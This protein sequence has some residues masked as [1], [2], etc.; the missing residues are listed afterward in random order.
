MTLDLTRAVFW[1]VHRNYPWEPSG[2]STGYTTDS[3]HLP[4]LS[5][6]HGLSGREGLKRYRP[7]LHAW[8]SMDIFLCRPR[9]H[10]HSYCKLTIAMAV[11]CPE[12]TFGSLSPYF[13]A[14]T[15]HLPLPQHSQNLRGIGYI[16]RLGLSTHVSLISALYTHESL[17]SPP[18]TRKDGVSK[19]ESNI[20]LLV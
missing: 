11:S 1:A 3:L 10:I 6:S 13:L 19:S 2:V 15:F 17:H 20:C 9:A 4:S 8:L 16:S 5:V 12:D 7:S 18:I 14:L